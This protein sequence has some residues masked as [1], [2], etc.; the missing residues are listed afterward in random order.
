MKHLM[1]FS[2][3]S[4][5]SVTN[6]LRI[7]HVFQVS[8]THQ[9]TLRELNRTSTAEI[10]N[11]GTFKAAEQKKEEKIRFALRSAN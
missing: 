11:H 1:R 9:T 10:Q 3:F 5:S 2:V 8:P 4:F 7:V 6:F